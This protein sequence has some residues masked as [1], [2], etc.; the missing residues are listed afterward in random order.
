MNRVAG[1]A[2]P[3]GAVASVT[4]EEAE[5][6]WQAHDILGLGARAD[7]VRRQR[8]GD[9]VT[10]VRVATVTIDTAREAQWPAAARE[11]RIVGRP[12]DVSEAEQA[13]GAVVR[14]AEGRPVTAFSL[15]DLHA[16]APEGARFV[17]VL[18]RLFGAGLGAVAAADVDGL[19]DPR[20]AVEAVLAAGGRVARFTVDRTPPGSPVPLFL[21]VRALQEAT[22]AVRAFAPLAR[23]V[24]A[25]TPTTGYEDVKSVAIA[26]LLV[27]NVGSIQVDWALHG[28]KLAQVALLFGADDLDAVPADDESAAG[29]RRAP[30]EEVKRN[31]RAASLTAVER[32]GRFGV[33]AP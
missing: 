6:L 8:H 5:R 7:A 17:D 1:G 22:G 32:D 10:F 26:R 2:D 4:P 3:V 18:T 24:E 30:L 15:G 27:D 20:P 11:I 14:R 25:S 29:Q 13:V 19:D 12:R 33:L 23:T 16:L 28:P 9:R 21:T 31:I